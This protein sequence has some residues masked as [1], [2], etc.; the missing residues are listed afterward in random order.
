MKKAYED[1]AGG[2]GIIDTDKRVIAWGAE[3]C[4]ADVDA[5]TDIVAC[6]DSD[7]TDWSNFATD[8][9]N[10]LGDTA[11]DGHELT[12]SDYVYSLDRPEVKIIAEVID[13]LT[14]L[15]PERMGNNGRK[16]ARI[17]D[18]SSAAAIL[19]HMTSPAKKRS[20]PENGKNGGRPRKPT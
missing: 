10:S 16:W 5:A 13:G 18:P 8:D 11:E 15:Y 20:S 6:L 19:G 14:H 1:N 12:Y 3:Q 17:I 9:G 4:L 7:L 2:L